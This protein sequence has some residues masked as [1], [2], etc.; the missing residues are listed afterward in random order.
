VTATR[1][2][3]ESA[4]RPNLCEVTCRREAVG[5][6]ACEVVCDPIRDRTP[7][8]ERVAAPLTV[9][10]SQVVRL[11]STEEESGLVTSELPES[12]TFVWE[13][14][15][16]LWRDA[17]AYPPGNRLSASFFN[18]PIGV[19]TEGTPVYWSD[20]VD[21]NVEAVDVRITL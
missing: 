9:D 6:V 15:I 13:D 2:C 14:P 11:P 3:E 16:S 12:V 21:E 7:R 10:P 18:Q 1:K 20:L 17:W 5:R 8:A 19:N 4:L